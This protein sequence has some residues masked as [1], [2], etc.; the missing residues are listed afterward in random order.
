MIF[1]SGAADC[2]AELSTKNNGRKT[3]RTICLYRKILRLISGS[4][5]S[6]FENRISDTTIRFATAKVRTNIQCN[7]KNNLRNIKIPRSYM[8]YPADALSRIHKL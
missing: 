3:L 1:R 2:V 5:K 8:S 4:R 7:M 6:N